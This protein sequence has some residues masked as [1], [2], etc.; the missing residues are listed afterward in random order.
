WRMH[1]VAEG[2][3]LASIGK[4]YGSSA[5]LIVAAN[6]LLTTDPVAGD[7]LAIPASY[8]EPVVRA[9]AG[10]P[11]VRRATGT[12]PP[13]TSGSTSTNRPAGPAR[14]KGVKPT[15]PATR[16]NQP[17]R[18]SPKILTHTAYNR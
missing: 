6:K 11:P 17:P 18:K 14:R 13:A 8:R 5:N 10:R 1:K 12:R 16:T 7:R 2:E 9:K 3:T 4:R 15:I